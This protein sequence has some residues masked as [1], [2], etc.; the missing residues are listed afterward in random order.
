MKEIINRKDQRLSLGI[1]RRHPVR[2]CFFPPLIYYY[3]IEIQSKDRT[4]ESRATEF[5]IAIASAEREFKEKK[6]VK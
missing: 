4:A 2:V 5:S 3:R 6:E 1:L